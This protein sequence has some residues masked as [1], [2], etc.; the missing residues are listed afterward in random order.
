MAAVRERVLPWLAPLTSLENIMR[1]YEL[2]PGRLAYPGSWWPV[3]GFLAGDEP[4]RARAAFVDHVGEGVHP[5]RE[6]RLLSWLDE[7]GLADWSPL[8]FSQRD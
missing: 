1:V 8:L 4:E 2:S 3:L 6:E 5:L 7:Q